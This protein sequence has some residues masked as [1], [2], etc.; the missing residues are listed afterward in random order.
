MFVENDEELKVEERKANHLR[1]AIFAQYVARQSLHRPFPIGSSSLTCR[2]SRSEDGEST[3]P[4]EQ[5]GGTRQA[6]FWYQAYTFEAI[7]S[8]LSD[9]FFR[10]VSLTRMLTG[11]VLVLAIRI[12]SLTCS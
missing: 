7:A 3:T 12:M 5:V 4:Y 6:K 8:I 1:F 11:S 10:D 2:V 9:R